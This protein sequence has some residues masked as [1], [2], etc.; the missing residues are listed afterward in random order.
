M[1]EH[2]PTIGDC[3]EQFCAEDLYNANIFDFCY[4]VA[5][6]KTAALAPPPSLKIAKE[7]I[8]VLACSNA[9]GSDKRKLM[10]TRSALKPRAF[11]KKA[12]AEHV[13]DHHAHQYA[14]MTCHLFFDWLRRFDGQTRNIKTQKMLLLVENCSA[15][16]TTD[17]L[18]PSQVTEGSVFFLI[19]LRI[20]NLG[21]LVSS[22]QS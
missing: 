22:L 15:H 6:A 18:H 5:P 11:K 1:D 12:G 13:F 9:D 16:G 4:R 17:K 3:V 7:R 14:W 2:Q 19:P 8:Y 20:Y 10:M 21:M